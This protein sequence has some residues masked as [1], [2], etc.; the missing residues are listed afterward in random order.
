MKRLACL[1]LAMGLMVGCES[2]ADKPAGGGAATA[3]PN[4]GDLMNK[5]ASAMKDG[6]AK[7]EEA[8][9]EGAAKVEEVAK[10]GAAKVE[11]GA[12]KAEE[13]VKKEVEAVKE[14][15]TGTKP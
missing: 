1:A 12:A 6:A 14:A 4:P 2:A 8:V 13:A 5:S 15:A 7:A 10:E 11:A 9:K 3:S